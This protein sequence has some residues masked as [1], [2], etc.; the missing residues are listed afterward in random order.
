MKRPASVLLYT[1]AFVAHILR[2]FIKPAHLAR[3]CC[4]TP[5]AMAAPS[6]ARADDGGMGVDANQDVR[7]ASIEPK[8][9]LT[10]TLV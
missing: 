2:L 1:P 4:L 3:L 8:M 10:F 6:E 5:N 7:S 9:E